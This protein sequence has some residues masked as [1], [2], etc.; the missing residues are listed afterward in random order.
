MSTFIIHHRNRPLAATRGSLISAAIFYCLL[1]CTAPAL[2]AAEEEVADGDGIVVGTQNAGA[3]AIARDGAKHVVSTGSFHHKLPLAVA[4]DSRRVFTATENLIHEKSVTGKSI[5]NSP[6]ACPASGDIKAIGV[7]PGGDRLFVISEKD[8][9]DSD[10]ANHSLN[11]SV[12]LLGS[13]SVEGNEIYITVL[14]ISDELSSGKDGARKQ[15]RSFSEPVRL[16]GV[17]YNVSDIAV[18]PDGSF[19]LVTAKGVT[20]PALVTP[21]GVQPTS[22]DA[23]AGVFV[24]DL[25][26]LKTVKFLPSALSGENTRAIRLAVASQAKGIKH[27]NLQIAESKFLSSQGRL[28]VATSGGPSAFGLGAGGGVFLEHIVNSK[29]L[30][31]MQRSY[32]KFGFLVAYSTTYPFDMIEPTGVGINNRG[33]MAMVTMH[34]TNNIGVLPISVTTSPSGRTQ[35]ALGQ[36]SFD[37]ASPKVVNG[38][39]LDFSINPGNGARSNHPLMWFGPSDVAFSADDK[40]ALVGAYGGLRGS[41]GMVDIERNRDAVLGGNSIASFI[42]AVNTDAFRQGGSPKHVAWIPNLDN[43][44]DGLSNH[45][46]AFNRW[47]DFRDIDYGNKD[48]LAGVALGGISDINV[49]ERTL[50]SSE[51]ASVVHYLLPHSGMGYRFDYLG[52]E[53][54]SVN[55]GNRVAIEAIERLGKIWHEAYKEKAVTR[56]YFIVQNIAQ[57]G[58]GFIHNPAGELIHYSERM[59]DA[60]NFSYLRPEGDDLPFDVVTSNTPRSPR[61]NTISS[62]S[63]MDI[64][65]TNFLIDLLL[66]DPAVLEIWI[67]PEV[68]AQYSGASG[69]TGKFILR[70][71]LDPDSPER[72]DCD[73]FMKVVFGSSEAV[74]VIVDGTAAIPDGEGDIIYYDVSQRDAS[75]SEAIP[76]ALKFG[77]S[78]VEYV[79]FGSGVDLYYDEAFSEKVELKHTLSGDV[80]IYPIFKFEAPVFMKTNQAVQVTVYDSELNEITTSTF[81][82]KDV[83]IDLSYS[84]PSVLPADSLG[85]PGYA[86]GFDLDKNKS[87][88]LN[89]DRIPDDADDTGSAIS[90][91]FTAI[92]EGASPD[93]YVRISYQA[94]APSA[95]SRFTRAVGS[96]P[97]TY[98]TYYQLPDEGLLRLWKSGSTTR[99]LADFVAPGTYPISEIN[100]GN[101]F[102][103]AVKEG[104]QG[105]V[106]EFALDPDGPGPA[107]FLVSKSIRIGSSG[108]LSGPSGA[109]DYGD[110]V[111]IGVDVEPSSTVRLDY[112][113]RFLSIADTPP[114]TYSGAEI[115]DSLSV[116][117]IAP[118]DRAGSTS[119]FVEEVTLAVVGGI[120]SPDYPPT[121]FSIKEVP[122]TPSVSL[123]DVLDFSIEPPKIEW[124]RDHHPEF[125][126]DPLLDGDEIVDGDNSTS[127]LAEVSPST[128]RKVKYAIAQWIPERFAGIS[129]TA[130]P[131]LDE[132]TGEIIA[133]DVAGEFYVYAYDEALE[134]VRT[135]PLLITIGGCKSCAS[136][137]CIGASAQTTCVIDEGL[138]TEIDLGQ[139]GRILLRA[140]RPNPVLATPDALLYPYDAGKNEAI[141]DAKR[142]LSQI[143]GDEVFVDIS[144]QNSFKYTISVYDASDATQLSDGTY[145][146]GADPTSF[147]VVQNP[148]P[149][150]Y[151]DGQRLVISHTYEGKE[152][153]RRYSFNESKSTWRLDEGIDPNTGKP[154]RST[155]VSV[156]RAAN[157]NPQSIYGDG[158]VEE[159]KTLGIDEQGDEI[160]LAEEKIFYLESD[161]GSLITQDQTVLEERDDL[162]TKY[163]YNSDGRLVEIRYPD[164]SRSSTTYDS[165][166]MQSSAEPWTGIVQGVEN[167]EQETVYQYALNTDLGDTAIKLDAP[168]S[169][170]STIGGTTISETRYAYG[171][172]FMRVSR[173]GLLTT[174]YYVTSGKFKGRVRRVVHPDLTET[175]YSY[176]DAR[177]ETNFIVDRT[178]VVETGT[179]NSAG[180]AI[181]DGTRSTSTTDFKNQQIFSQTV[182]IESGIIT[183]SRLATAYDAHGRVTAYVHLD[184]RT[185]ERQYGCCGIQWEKDLNG[186][187]TEYTYDDLKRVETITRLGITTTYDYDGL[188]RQDRVTQT[189]TEGGIIT[190]SRMDY[191]DASG[192]EYT[193]IDPLGRE[194][195]SET[196]YLSGGGTRT[197]TTLPGNF[198]QIQNY[199]QTGQLLNT[200][201]TAAT[202]AVF[203]YRV[204][205]EN[206]EV[207]TVQRTIQGDSP[208]APE[209]VEQWADSLGRNVRTVYPDGAEATRHYNAKGQL[210]RTTDPDGVTTLYAYNALGQQYLTAVDANRNGAIDQDGDVADLVTRTE[211]EYASVTIDGEVYDVMR[212]SS[213]VYT[214]TGA[215][216]LSVSES[217]VDGRHNWSTQGE[218]T[219]SRHVLYPETADGSYEVHSIAADGSYQVQFYTDG[220]LSNT[221]SYASDDSLIQSLSFGYDQFGRQDAVTHPRNGTTT[222]TFYDDGQIDTVITPDPERGTGTLLT[223]HE[224]NARGLLETRTLPDLSTVLFEY[225]AR[226]QLEK[227][228]GS[229][230]Y[231]VKYT[232][233]D[234][235]R[236]ETM[237]TWQDY[238]GQ[239]DAAITEW[240]Y[241]PQRGWLDKKIYAEQSEVPPEGG[242]GTV[243]NAEDEFIDY[244]Y[245]AAGRLETRTWARGISTT[246]DYNYAGQLA[247]TDYS[248]DTPDIAYSYYRHGQIKEVRD[249]VLSSGAISDQDLRYRH[250][251]TYDSY[252][253]PLTERIQTHGDHTLTRSYESSGAGQVPGR[254]RGYALTE[255]GGQSSVIAAATYGYDNAGRLQHVA[256]V[257]PAAT[258]N[259]Q[260][261]ASDSLYTYHYRADANLIDRIEAPAHTA[262]RAYQPRGSQVRSLINHTADPATQVSGFS[263]PPSH[264]S[265]INRHDY[266]YNQLGQ[267][268]DLVQSGT[269][270]ALEPA[271]PTASGSV[272][273]F[274]YNAKGE[275]TGAARYQ[276]LD[277]D[278]LTTPISNDTFAY[279][280]DDI[281]NR[282]TAAGGTLSPVSAPTTYEADS[283]NQYTSVTPDGAPEVIRQHDADGNLKQDEDFTYTWNGE[284]RLVTVTPVDPQS[285]DR[286]LS[287]T[288]DYQGRRVSKQSETWNDTTE[289]WETSDE[290]AYTY[291]GWNLIAT[292]KSQLSG[293][294][295][296]STYL[297]GTDL[298]G[299]LQGAGG[300]GGLLQVTDE[301]G[302][303]YS[304]YYD[305]NG[306]IVGY[307][308]NSTGTV[309]AHYEYGPFG[310]LIRATGSK[311]DE[312]NFRFST[313]YEDAETGLLYYGFRYYDPQTGR[314]LSRDPIGERGG[315]NLYG[316]VGN[317]PVNFWDYLGLNGGN[318]FDSGITFEISG[319][320]IREEYGEECACLLKSVTYNVAGGLGYGD[321]NWEN[322]LDE[323]NS[324][325]NLLS[326]VPTS[327]NP[328]D[329]AIHA[330]G[331]LLQLPDISNA[332]DAFTDNQKMLRN[333]L[334]DYEVMTNIDYL[335]QDGY[336][337]KFWGWGPEDKSRPLYKDGPD[338]VRMPNP[339][340]DSNS[341]VLAAAAYLNSGGDLDDLNIFHDERVRMAPVSDWGDDRRF[342]SYESAVRAAFEQL[343]RH[344][345]AICP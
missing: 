304:P 276:G 131:K 341:G 90:G 241:D 36:I 132:D 206:G 26:T 100:G 11:G 221:A 149:Q 202:P 104:Y 86:D 183:Q 114:G 2:T 254:Y 322:A 186:I 280:F 19:A 168:R 65:A 69:Q 96:S 200:G 177:D 147:I 337:R 139:A 232:Y 142:N 94:S 93:A 61:D 122:V 216:E 284:N 173:E 308:D 255:T 70:G 314:W 62:L 98:N 18:S 22:D 58:G 292:F 224:Y 3:V 1:C 285:G 144:V 15:D 179:P 220:R 6:Y 21:F 272:F 112:D 240:V 331:K 306:N 320:F 302:S 214:E 321:D 335:V 163:D 279:T 47:N 28:G 97:F 60:V 29:V 63:G 218:A 64:D 32:G 297:W 119:I 334:P 46:E 251:Y 121:I 340:Y 31:E 213:T 13:D 128:G 7:H 205:V 171:A 333:T 117:A 109:L 289:D 315:L 190:R 298:S 74:Q 294:I 157:P 324:S 135:E 87:E 167:P 191:P 211:R 305:A 108:I 115:P 342:D 252:L 79:S 138:D 273:D 55:S 266:R 27:A 283:L 329:V 116:T 17:A 105:S 195:T 274:S 327:I 67:D 41:Y 189:G 92:F 242:T 278:S 50:V 325:V 25:N 196:I 231:P 233:T 52:Q 215:I 209:W 296:Q 222:Y 81:S 162:I 312:F 180:T 287:F 85:I 310:E 249:G 126:L 344:I 178:T 194:T 156:G 73:S 160:V 282:K 328:L 164:G 12:N 106:I 33:D 16:E 43:D 256:P 80:R 293:F 155:T 102:F 77:S 313:K 123:V 39:N 68:A 59:G 295:P 290:V 271:S 49:P 107:G 99:S 153:I 225:N 291:D 9:G 101:L 299:T 238:A 95:V 244:D 30:Q 181:I 270:Y 311:K 23:T 56:P 150:E 234:Q 37:S 113:Q 318:P 57:P 120:P 140:K 42:S 237:T 265:I 260:L 281:G 198:T 208:S 124:S 145:T 165:D 228:H 182:D 332:F 317:N 88:T 10:Q 219:G 174:T 257:D 170:I 330:G 141:Y 243:G 71:S 269:A 307:F 323:L 343:D 54:F 48:A 268:K 8:V 203:K 53:K 275:V 72:R 84:G 130:E 20:A 207:F 217:S 345:K 210:N 35:V 267:R 192:L 44:G 146:T 226:G 83:S 66:E 40:K 247:T 338:F 45:V 245:T 137:S 172:D 5:G 143:V 103:E 75:G 303:T 288:Y 319:D 235:G 14:N 239:Q 326:Y 187:R 262:L 300:V 264:A 236:L 286:K 246:Y 151:P 166:R 250:H 193:S 38:E 111:S 336:E 110:T 185:T 82:R 154:E 158:F 204:E 248:D 91:T 316:M 133:G 229:Q 161:L 134:S 184:G 261:Q 169:I 201:G 223:D 78:E 89:P 4:P 159:R 199:S 259:S 309:A 125:Y 176:S 152:T 175:H 127:V 339:E 76:L 227:T 118:T 129:D 148:S 197:I 230:T 212:T 51:G 24:V 301:T 136:G 34:D 263:S 258:S 277:P 188:G 253:R